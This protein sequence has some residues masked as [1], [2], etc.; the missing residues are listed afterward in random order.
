MDENNLTTIG[1]SP[2]TKGR[3]EAF[4]IHQNQSFDEILNVL[5]D[6]LDDK[7]KKFTNK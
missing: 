2:K 5:M 4:K 6:F 7:Y 3:L 1:L